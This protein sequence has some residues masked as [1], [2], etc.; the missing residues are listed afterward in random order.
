MHTFPQMIHLLEYTILPGMLDRICK[1]SKVVKLWA[2]FD[3]RTSFLIHYA[4]SH[5]NTCC[6]SSHCLVNVSYSSFYWLYIAY[7]MNRGNWSTA[8]LSQSHSSFV[9]WRSA[10]KL[11]MFSYSHSSLLWQTLDWQSGYFMFIRQTWIYSCSI[12]MLEHRA[13]EGLSDWQARE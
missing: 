1:R 9:E 11:R 10:T 3:P 13:L 5:S 7:N 8:S 2:G 6:C 4:S 12:F